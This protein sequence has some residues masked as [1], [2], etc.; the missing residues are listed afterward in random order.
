MLKRNE[1]LHYEKRKKT[2]NLKC[3]LLTETSQPEN[4]TYCMI[5]TMW[6]SEKGKTMDTIKRS[7]IAKDSGRGKDYQ[8][9]QE[10]F[11][12]QQN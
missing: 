11:L 4:T 8:V 6:H 10:G 5:P 2:Q 1:L 12:R 7:V 9:K 3:I